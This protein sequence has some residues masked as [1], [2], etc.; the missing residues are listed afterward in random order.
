MRFREI[1]PHE[2]NSHEEVGKLFH[3]IVDLSRE[4][5]SNLGE[6][7][8][9]ETYQ[10]ALQ[11]EM[12]RE[13]ICFQREVNIEIFYKG[14]PI[15]F[16]RPDFIVRPFNNGSINLS[17]PVVIE[18]KAV[19]KLNDKHRIQAK[20]YLRSLPHS[21]DVQLKN[22]KHCILINFTEAEDG[23]LEALL[24]ERL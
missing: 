6:G 16:D 5:Y 4:V 21:S 17:L 9:E 14:H 10:R 23:D 11:I 2:A 3:L 18:L 1:Y 22:C 24:V 20:T 7:F 12:R 15:G 19:K 13:G 8:T